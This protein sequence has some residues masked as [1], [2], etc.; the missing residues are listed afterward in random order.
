VDNHGLDDNMV[1]LKAPK[2]KKQL[3]QGAA[4]LE[5]LPGIA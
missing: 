1:M 4:L 3:P 5:N 2:V